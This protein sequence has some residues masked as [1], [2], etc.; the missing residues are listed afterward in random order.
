MGN[1]LKTYTVS[2]FAHRS[3][4]ARQKL[5]CSFQPNASNEFGRGLIEQI[6][7][8]AVKMSSAHTDPICQPVYRKLFI[9]HFS[10]D[11]ISKSFKKY[12][13]VG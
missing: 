11:G 6:A 12:V 1:T 4:I 2:H 7:K 13:I 5:H 3:G 10:L 9:A 8:S